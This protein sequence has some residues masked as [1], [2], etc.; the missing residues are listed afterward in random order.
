M[1][2]QDRSWQNLHFT[3]LEILLVK[4]V[5]VCAAFYMFSYTYIFMYSMKFTYS[6]RLRLTWGQG[7]ITQY[8]MREHCFGCLTWTRLLL[9]TSCTVGKITLLL[10]YVL[11]FK[12]FSLTVS[13][14]LFWSISVLPLQSRAGN[15]S[16]SLKQWHKTLLM[17]EERSPKSASFKLYL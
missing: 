7:G 11:S 4:A 5:I 10:V 13:C 14:S 16:Q 17:D 3:M 2:T 6:S 8:E 12:L 9:N 1:E 15:Q